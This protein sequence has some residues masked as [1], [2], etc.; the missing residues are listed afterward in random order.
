MV[1]TDTHLE[2]NDTDMVLRGSLHE[3]YVKHS[4]PDRQISDNILTSV[5]ADGCDLLDFNFTILEEAS[6]LYHGGKNGQ[7]VAR[8]LGWSVGQSVGRFVAVEKEKD[9]N[10]KRC[11]R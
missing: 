10:E 4:D 1:R 7:S 3:I 5:L 2:L 9:K 8:S 11:M 6:P